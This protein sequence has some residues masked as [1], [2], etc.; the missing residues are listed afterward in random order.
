MK[1]YDEMIELD[2][3]DTIME[4]PVGFK[5]GCR[6]LFLY[7]VTLGKTLLLS[8]MIRKLEVNNNNVAINPYLE[9]M[10]V[11]ESKRNIVCRLI[12]IHTFNSRRMLFN[13]TIIANRVGVIDELDKEELANLLIILLTNDSVNS[14]IKYLGIDKEQEDIAKITKIKSKDCSS[15]TFGGKSILGSWVIPACEK[16]NMTPQEVIWDISLDL[17]RL[18]MAD[19]VTSIYLTKEER[20]KARVSQ[21]REHIN[22]DDPSNWEKIKKMNWD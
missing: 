14:F 11:C 21:D 16:L 4:R 13:E 12:A 6:Q 7:P 18:M 8:R 17:L 3:A 22:A 9:A 15:F 19:A 10:R 5:V 1:K 2:I 20:K